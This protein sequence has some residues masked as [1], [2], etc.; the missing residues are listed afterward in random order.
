MYYQISTLIQY[1][2]EIFKMGVIHIITARY[3]F[4]ESTPIYIQIM[5]MIK[6]RICAGQ[7]SRGEKLPSVRD[8][9]IELR[10]NPNTVQRA[11]QEL[12]REEMVFTQRGMGTFVSKDKDKIDAVRKEL[13][14]RLA[15]QFVDG[16]F[17]LGFAKEQIKHYVETYL[18]NGHTT[19]PDGKE[20]R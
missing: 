8:M 14:S 10:V 11:Y 18:E 15:Q 5:D 4:D 20:R 9:A 6:Q 2:A 19:G 3:V 12:E 16:M 13:A 1:V 7:L 17:S